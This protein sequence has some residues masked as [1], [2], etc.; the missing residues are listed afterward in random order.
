MTTLDG[1]PADLLGPGADGRPSLEQFLR[2]AE[3]SR[4]EWWP[5][6]GA[7]RVV[8]WQASRMRGAARLRAE[9]VQ[10]L[11]RQPRG[12]PADDRD[13]VH[14]PRQP[15]RP[16]EGQAEA[17]GQLRRARARARGAAVRPRAWA[18]PA[19][20]SPSSS[21]AR[22]SSASTP[23]SPRWT[24]SG[25]SLRK[26]VPD[27]LP[28]L[29]AAFIPLD[30]ERTTASRSASRDWGWSGLP[31]DNQADD[32]LLPTEFTETWVP[33]AAHARGHAAAEH[34]LHRAA[35][36]RTRRTGAPARTRGSCTARCRRR[37]GSA[38]RTPPATTSGR[39]ACSASTRT[40]S[41][42]TPRTRPRRSSRGL[43]DLLREND[44]PFRLHWGKFQPV[45]ERGDRDWVD[46]FRAQYPR[47]DDFLRLRAE[48]DPNNIFLTDYWRDRF[49]LWDEPEP[50]PQA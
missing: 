23:R 34:V 28:K 2:D 44:V 5:Q 9:A 29:I 17:R 7:E 38:R 6:R 43:W 10:A 36:R 33:L 26:A 27:F 49:G 45:Y 3:F 42:T 30:S 22:S 4:L 35:R 14:D 39:T 20:C 40:G 37:S 11:R 21:A 16:L 41:P 50:A 48:R 8:T 12:D 13:P 1:G 47:W 24:R 18:P 31:M 15:R 25:G 19:G 32:E 46:F